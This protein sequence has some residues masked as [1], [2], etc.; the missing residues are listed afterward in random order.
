MDPVITYDYDQAD[1]GAQ[2]VFDDYAL[3]GDWNVDKFVC[4]YGGNP[5]FAGDPVRAAER[6]YDEWPS[7]P[8]EMRVLRIYEQSH[9]SLGW[10]AIGY[11]MAIGQSGKTY[12]L[13][14]NNPAGATS[15]DYE[16]DGIRENAEAFAILLILG[17]DQVPSDA[18]LA[19]LSRIINQNPGIRPVINHKDVKGTT[20]CPGPYISEYVWNEAWLLAL[21]GEIMEYLKAIL[22]ATIDGAWDSDNPVIQGQESVWHDLIDRMDDVPPEAIRNEFKYLFAALFA[23]IPHDHV[24]AEIQWGEA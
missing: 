2:R 8:A 5:N 16:D 18:M 19:T 23:P 21:D 20:S 6:G 12:R 24:D 14:G 9:L 15:G 3:P 1:W 22:H 4:H 10:R 7:V 13:R 17:G 11:S